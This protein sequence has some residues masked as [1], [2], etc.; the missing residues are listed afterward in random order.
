[1]MTVKSTVLEMEENQKSQNEIVAIPVQENVV[2]PINL[3]KT[4]STFSRIERITYFIIKRVFD[5]LCS[6]FGILMLIP[7]SLVT[8][9]CYIAVGD[10]KSIF[11]KQ[12]RVGKNGKII[13]I[14]KF[15]SM[16]YNADEVLKELLKDPKYRKEW[17][18]NQKFEN[19]PRVTKIGKILR[20]TSLDE[21]PQFINVLKGDM[22]LIGP[23]PL[24]E[25]ELDAH[26]GNPMIYQ[27]VRPGISG[28]WAANGRSATTYEKRLEL[29]YYYCK[30]CNLILDIKCVFLTIK[31]V[32]YKEGAK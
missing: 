30:N 8:K 29:E 16:V 15:R 20:K 7:I 32:L 19:D 9:I 10:K 24:V 14:Y 18:I 12:K 1:M 22:S 3:K 27:S 2:L 26:K 17:D 21:I 11:Y 25:G 13:Y 28:W 5:I 23:R 4:E 6:I 31:A